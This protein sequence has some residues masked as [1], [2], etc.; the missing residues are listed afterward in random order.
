MAKLFRTV[1][2]KGEL[3]RVWGRRGCTELK[4]KRCDEPLNII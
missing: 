1:K 3:D 4:K 2:L